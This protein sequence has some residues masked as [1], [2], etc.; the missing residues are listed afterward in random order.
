MPTP[1]PYL[2][3]PLAL[4]AVFFALPLCM[5]VGISLLDFSHNLYAPQFVG[6][7]N[8]QRLLASPGFWQ[9]LQNSLFLLVGMV[10]VMTVLS[11]L[12]ALV[13]NG[14]LPGM[15]LF[16]ALIYVPVVL[17][18]V[19]VGIAWKWL[20][21]TDG[22]L[23][24]ALGLVGVAPVPWLVS[25]DWALIAIMAMI[26]WKGVAYYAMMILAHLQAIS[27]DL[28]QAAELDGANRFWQHWH[29]T[30][31][32]IRPTLTL[33]VL[34]CSIG[35][36]KVFTEVVVMTNGGPLGSTRTLI[37]HLYETAFGQLDLGL[38]SAMGLVFMALLGALAWVQYRLTASEQS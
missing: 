16:R 4:L 33:I 24:Y 26:I 19:V 22:L 34:I 20:Y 14:R 38:A 23:N 28:Y 15:A 27:A 12:L 32:A 29:I 21:A 5:A 1:L 2:L 37:F 6:L 31:P 11:V 3:L 18:I 25:A 13:L 10:P 36:L 9:S 7:Q 30:L 35:S 17:S 8:Y